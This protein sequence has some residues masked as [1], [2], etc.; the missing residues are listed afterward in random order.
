MSSRARC[1]HVPHPPDPTLI[2]E[3]EEGLHK[4]A[5]LQFIAV[6]LVDL[7]R[8]LAYFS[9]DAATFAV[10]FLDHGFALSDLSYHK[11]YPR[12][13]WKNQ[14]FASAER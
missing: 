8:E 2:V 9:Q 13:A 14:M 4:S 10:Y 6:V 7:S 12:H 3:L 11:F 1:G 5:H